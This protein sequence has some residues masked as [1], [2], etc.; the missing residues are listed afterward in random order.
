MASIT[1]S[2][3]SLSTLTVTQLDEAA[4][5]SSTS[6]QLQDQPPAE[7]PAGAPA[8]P[9]RASRPD[10]ADPMPWPSKEEYL[11]VKAAK[12]SMHFGLYAD[13]D[14]L[15]DMLASRYPSLRGRESDDLFLYPAL[16]YLRTR[17]PG[18]TFDIGLHIGFVSQR[19][20]DLNPRIPAKVGEKVLVL[21]LFALEEESY[22]N[23]MT[24]KEV[25]EI[26]EL[27]GTKPTWWWIAHS[28]PSI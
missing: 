21:G 22:F 15:Q 28:L 11:R 24:Q 5:T 27:M 2:M 16:A 7:S 13:D 19:V 9:R 23:R 25:D 18:R 1:S 14:V 8:K 3:Q 6:T 17:Y 12:G 4:S 26:S 10:Q 20:K